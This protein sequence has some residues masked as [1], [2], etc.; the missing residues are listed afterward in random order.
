MTLLA[1]LFVA[2]LVAATFII[3]GR[4]DSPRQLGE[5]TP[6]RW[7]LQPTGAEA[8]LQDVTFVDSANGWAVGEGGTVVHTSDAGDTWKTQ[9]SGVDIKLASVH[10]VNANLGW[11]V[12]KLGVIIHTPD[13]G[14]TWR[15]QGAEDTL[16]LNLTA[17]SFADEQTGWVVTERG[18]RLLRTDDAGETWGRQFLSNTGS[19]SDAVFL[20]RQRGW[21]VFSQGSFLYTSDGGESWQ[22]QSGINGVHIGAIGAFFLDENYG[23]VAGWRGK[24]TGVEFARFLSDGMVARTTD[25]GRSWQRHDSGT[26]RFLHDVAFV[27]PLEGWAVGS[28]GTILYSNDGGFTWEPQP[29]GTQENLRGISFPAANNGWAVGDRGTI[30]RFSR[31]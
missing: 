12:G 30:L 16:G 7:T 24:G 10:F 27:S 21:I 20:D 18:S 13:G 19:R 28:F 9:D 26:G 23:W 1:L 11:A 5:G 8:D 6:G 4:S 22:F 17:V 3:T 25:G 29:S 14:K 2:G 15:R 31:P